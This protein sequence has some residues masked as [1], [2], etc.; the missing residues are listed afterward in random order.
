MEIKAGEVHGLIGENGAGKSTL[1]K[2]LAGIYRPEG[3][4]VKIDGV[5]IE[6]GRPSVLYK[7]GLR[8]IHQELELVPTFNIAEQVFLGQEKT[9]F[10]RMDTREMHRAL[11]HFFHETLDFPISSTALI[12]DLGTAARKLVQVAMALIDGQAKYVVFDEPTAPL[13]SREID[14]LLRAIARLRERG[15]GIL[16]VSHYL[17]EVL[18]LCDRVTVLRNGKAVDLIDPVLPHCGQQMVRAMVGRDLTSLYPEKP[19]SF[20]KSFFEVSSLSIAKS[21]TDINLHVRAGETVGLA[22]L[23][24]SGRRALIATLFGE[25]LW[26]KGTVTIDGRAK[27]FKS[28][29]DAVANHI[30]LLPGDR[31]HSG[32]VLD[33]NVRDNI[34]LP[35]M[36]A[37]ATLG[38]ENRRKACERAHDL[39]RALDIRPKDD[40]AFAR[41]L[42]GGNQQ[43]VVLAKWLAR[44][45]RLFLLEEPTVGVDVGAKSEIYGLVRQTASTGAGFLISSSDPAELAGL[46]DRV[47]VMVRGQIVAELSGKTLNVDQ[48]VAITT[49][50]IA[51]DSAQG[52]QGHLAGGTT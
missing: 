20:G 28:A 34:N 44:S 7:A 3:G 17:N 35:S 50:A 45:A 40:T 52:G 11:R 18:S 33:M 24:G 41:N 19:K 39:I 9:A 30:V 47:L 1:I 46:C 16:Y 23:A 31:R 5:E 15:I 12:R 27:R 37:V 10:L 29:A 6:P 21:F 36:E 42:S 48:I 43:K 14:I 26:Q 38:L 49:G 2:C 51:Q 32:L 25:M 22:G 4:G 8:F 13:P